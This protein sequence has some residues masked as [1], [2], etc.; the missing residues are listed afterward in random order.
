MKKIFIPIFICLC[1]IAYIVGYSTTTTTTNLLLVK[2]A[3][4]DTTVDYFDTVNANMDL[5]DAIFNTVSLTEFG[6]LDGVTSAIQTQLGLR[7]LKTEIDAETE[8]EAIWGVG[9]AHSGA[10]SDI[11]SLTGLTTALGAAYGGTGIANNAAE[12]ITIGGAGT[13]AL[14]L[15]LTNT[16]NVTL[17]TTGTVLTNAA[18][19]IDSD[20][21]VDASIDHEHLAPDVISGLT[22]VTSADA[23]YMMIWDATDSALKKVDMAEVRGAGGGLAATDIDTSA[24]I[25]AIVGDETGTGVLVYGTS[26]TFTTNL[27]VTDLIYFDNTVDYNIKL[28]YQAGKN[29]ASG[30]IDNTF[31]GYQAGYFGATSTNAADYNIAV[32]YKSLYSNTTGSENTA[33]GVN[34][35]YS[36]TTGYENLALGYGALYSNTIGIE[37]IAIGYKALYT[38]VSGNDNFAMG[39]EVLRC[40]TTGYENT[41]IGTYSLWTNTEGYDNSALG[42]NALYANSTG[43]QNTAVGTYAGDKITT[44][45]SNTFVGYAAGDNASQKVDAVNSTALGANVYTTKSNQVVLG[46]TNIVETLLRGSIYIGSDYTAPT[47]RLHLPAG[48]ATASTAPLKFTSGTPLTTPEAGAVEF[49]TDTYYA[50]IT[51]GAARKSFAFR[52]D[53]LSAFAATTSAELAGVISDET[54]TDKLVYNTSPSLVTPTLGAASATSINLTGG[55][56]AFPATAAP[57]ADANTL[58]DYEEGTWTMGVSFGGGTTGIT[59]NRYTGYYTKIGNLVT[60]SGRLTLTSKGSSTGAALLTGLPFTVVNNDAGWAAAVLRVWNITFANQIMGNTVINTTTIELQE[61]TEAG[62]ST[63]LADTD[64]ANTSEIIVGCTYRIN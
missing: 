15:T 9:L 36:N 52:E 3:S 59:Y 17:P 51:T 54:G 57:S 64:F 34:A 6:Y 23:D 62:A 4:E 30:A 47:A 35:L 21:Y 48:T 60:I 61:L 7:Y 33:I 32:G 28:G 63:A 24:E 58:D 29:V 20:Q 41:S 8:M 40:N 12:T 1:L 38:N 10:N 18:N 49:Q 43:Y 56:I 45:N 39:V 26:P 16:T 53:K 11:T 42:Y 25:A 13:Y 22:D 14:T 5:I 46:D 31:V 37:N 19:T 55:Q 2:P 50:T 27:T 44:G